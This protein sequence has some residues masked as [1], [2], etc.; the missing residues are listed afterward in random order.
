MI[1]F[2]IATEGGDASAVNAL[3]FEG[4]RAIQGAASLA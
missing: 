1:S 3:V 4:C 2:L